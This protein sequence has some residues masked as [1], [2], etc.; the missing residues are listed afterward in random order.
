MASTSRSACTLVSVAYVLAALTCTCRAARFPY[1]YPSESNYPNT[2]KLY[3]GLMEPFSGGF[4][5]SG[6][7]PGI[8]VA[9]DQINSNSSILPGYSLHYILVDG[10]VSCCTGSLVLVATLWN[11]LHL[12]LSPDHT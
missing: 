2:T 1:I 11:A 8:E 10:K 7:V 4:D 5:G 3:F 9:L 12:S 6:T